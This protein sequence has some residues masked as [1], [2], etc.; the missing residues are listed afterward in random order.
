MKTT[1]HP[2]YREITVTCTSCGNTFKTGSTLAG[3]LSVEACSKC[4]P[5]FAGNPKLH[6]TTGRID[7]F[8]NRY[9][10]TRSEIRPDA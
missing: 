8:R 3:D 7:R 6:D 10:S 1:I 2:E 5:F 9:A 4:H